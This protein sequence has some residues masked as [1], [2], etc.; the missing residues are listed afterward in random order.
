MITLLNR[1][2]DNYVI[3]K[4]D[5]LEITN[6]YAKD[7]NL[8]SYIDDVVFSQ[9]GE[10]QYNPEEQVVSFDLDRMMDSNNRSFQRLKEEF[11]IDDKYDSY[12]INYYYLNYIYNVLAH[13]K[14]KAD[15]KSREDLL[16][17]LYD[18]SQRLIVDP[19][20]KLLIPMEREANNTGLLTAYTLMNYTKLPGKEAHVMQLQYLNGLLL[21]YKRRNNFQV[22]SPIEVLSDLAPNID[23]DRINELLDQSR[24]SRVD[25]INLGLPITPKEYDSVN[26]EVAKKLLKTN[27]NSQ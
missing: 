26:S 18:L 9:D 27:H 10:S 4:E 21:N 15:Y 16:G 22:T 11:Q 2:D 20:S 23:I 3:K 13:V 12:F 25:R 7:N 1:F 17:Y 6:K 19:K 14:Q 24:L 5:V 8:S